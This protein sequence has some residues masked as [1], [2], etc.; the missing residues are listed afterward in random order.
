MR[1]D[2]HQLAQHLQRNLS[3]LYVIV[4]D[5]TLLQIEAADRITQAARKQGY[6]EREVFTVE[7]G[8][9]WQRLLTSGNSLSLFAA[10]RIID[11]RIPTGKPG[12]EGAAALQQYCA[13]L[14]QDTVSIVTLPR[15]ERNAQHSD[16][17][18]ALSGAGAVIGAEPVTREQ[19]PQ[20]LRQRLALNQQDADEATLAFLV[21]RT[22]GNLLAARNEVEK[23][24]LL[25]PEGRLDADQVR[26]AVMDVARFDVFDLTAALLVGDAARYRRTLEGLQQEGEA[27]PLVLWNLC[28]ELRALAALL[29]GSAA[30][31]SLQDLM[32]EQRVWGPRQ[33]PMQRAVRRLRLPEVHRAIARAAGVDRM[34]KGVADGDAWQGLLALGLSLCGVPLMAGS[35]RDG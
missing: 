16:W 1:I 10:K 29:V 32:R 24:A 33:G 7:P 18:A 25:F 21:D 30:G 5:E 14:P 4:G 13:R 28:N 23:L 11:L 34:I 2:S 20:W 22:E 19:L 9:D 26:Q 15:L 6:S 12:V 17:F 31:R 35:S 27:A 8:F 3:A